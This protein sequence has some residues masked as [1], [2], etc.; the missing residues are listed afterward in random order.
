MQTASRLP[1]V[2]VGGWFGLLCL[3]FGGVGGENGDDLGHSAQNHRW[4]VKGW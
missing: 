1:L 2:G 4:R 3:F